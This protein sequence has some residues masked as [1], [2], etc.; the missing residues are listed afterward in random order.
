MDTTGRLPCAG[1]FPAFPEVPL[2]W[3]GGT[4]YP[5]HKCAT[6]NVKCHRALAGALTLYFTMGEGDFS[7]KGQEVPNGLPGIRDLR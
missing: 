6:P 4:V 3:G 7:V 2:H 5:G 1:L